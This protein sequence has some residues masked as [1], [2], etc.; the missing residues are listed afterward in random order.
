[1]E[2]KLLTSDFK[3]IGII[4]NPKSLTY[5]ECFSDAG[6]LY[7]EVDFSRELYAILKPP[8]RIL[9]EDLIFN[10]DKLWLQNGV[11]RVYASGIFAEFKQF[12]ISMPEQQ[13]GSAAD[14][15]YSFA[16]RASFDGIS[17]KVFGIGSEDTRVCESYEWCSDLYT[18]I[19]QLCYD[20]SLGFRII[21]SFEA[22]ELRFHLLDTRDRATNQASV[23]TVISDR[24]GTYSGIESVDDV[25]NYKNTI[26]LI[27]RI[28]ALGELVSLTYNRRPPNE[29]VRGLAV[30]PF[31]MPKDETE[32]YNM[33][34]TCAAKLF[35]D[36]RRK[37]YFNVTIAADA[38]YRVGDICFFESLELGERHYA[39]LTE[40]RVELVDTVPVETVTLE[41]Q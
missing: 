27:Y 38:K 33:Y 40:R 25:T 14:I 7:M 18:I 1:M 10:V 22:Q 15:L 32:L 37:R 35:K 6:T 39:L 34:A 24:L 13:S 17:Y 23:Y 11:I 36:H 41:V 12:Y 2:I 4:D 8:C 30:Y 26:E 16:S 31:I 28:N 21:Y 9:I 20:Y 3:L 29:S 19:N 5:T